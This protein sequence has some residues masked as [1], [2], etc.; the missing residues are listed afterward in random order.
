MGPGGLG[1]VALVG[2]GPG[3]PELLTLKGHRLLAAADAVVYDR[4][5]DPALVDLAPPA[6]QRFYV[7]KGRE[8][9]SIPQEQVHELLADLAR[10]GLDVVRLK[11]GDPYVFGRGGEEVDRLFSA[12]IPFDVVPGIS[13][14]TAVPA[15]AGIPVTDRR[16]ASS[17]AVV[18]GHLHPRDPLSS[19]D[20]AQ[21]ALSVDTIVILMGMRYL[22]DISNEL[23]RAGR[24]A[25][26][27]AAVIEAGT[28]ARQRTVCG[29]LRH[30]AVKASRAGV[31]APAVI[32]VGDVVALRTFVDENLAALD[33]D[34][35]RMT[36][37]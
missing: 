28:T 13:S 7:G 4:L 35:P 1:S 33:P 12:G 9:A 26:T 17:Y 24:P 15:A 20:W 30:L 5:V 37:P 3:D 2:A 21:L 27:P 22:D 6:A 18:T 8:V 19:V 31:E 16:A 11:G 10:R 25:D 14:A 32:V 23:V 36:A 29:T 34:A